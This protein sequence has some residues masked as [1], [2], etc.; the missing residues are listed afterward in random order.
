MELKLHGNTHKLRLSN[1]QKLF[2]GR[3][4]IDLLNKMKSDFTSTKQDLEEDMINIKETNTFLWSS[5]DLLI[6]R[7]H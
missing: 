5:L 2:H 3:P 4:E 1:P 7:L 6:F